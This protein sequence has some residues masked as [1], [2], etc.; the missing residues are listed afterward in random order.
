MSLV[1]TEEEL[2][3]HLDK[4]KERLEDELEN[5]TDNPLQQWADIKSLHSQINLLKEVLEDRVVL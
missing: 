4:L 1:R 5:D 2:R 3:E